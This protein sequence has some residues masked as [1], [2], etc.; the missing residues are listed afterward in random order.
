MPI[1][2]R[3]F[4]RFTSPRSP[5]TRLGTPAMALGVGL[6]S[7]S[8]IMPGQKPVSSAAAQA[9][10]CGPE[11][12]IDDMED[13]NNQTAVVEGRGGY[14]YTYVDDAG[15][16]VE[17]PAGS[18]GGTFTQSE[19]GANGSKFA[20]RVHG[21]LG[22]GSV[23]FGAMGMNFVDP[24]DT[25]D[26][27][28]YG[29]ISFWAKKGPGG[30]DKV[31]VKVP[32]INTDQ[33]GGICTACFNDF[34]QDITLTEAWQKYVVLFSKMRQQEYWGAPR[35]R[36]IDKTK[37]YGIQIQAQAPGATYDVWVDDIKFVGC[38]EE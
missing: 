12:L 35:P 29:G 19:G 37:V 16:T 4:L 17:P 23:I 25:Y 36:K 1:S 10:E 28:K 13:N 31:R 24:K 32:D 6:L 7:A 33:E 30:L 9:A 26:A 22:A 2:S 15:S 3:S 20:A 34:G 18:Q 8:C 14:W 11:G 5:L 27:S 38:G 21:K